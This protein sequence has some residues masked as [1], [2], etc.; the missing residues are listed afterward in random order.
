[1]PSS[2]FINSTSQ[3]FQTSA[4]IAQKLLKPT[5][6]SCN[7]TTKPPGNLSVFASA[8]KQFSYLL[9]FKPPHASQQ[10]NNTITLKFTYTNLTLKL[11][12]V[13]P[14]SNW[15]VPSSNSTHDS[16]SQKASKHQ[17]ST[18][19]APKLLNLAPPLAQSTWNR[20]PHTGSDRRAPTQL[21]HKRS[22][23]QS[24]HHHPQPSESGCLKTVPESR[25][26]NT[27]ANNSFQVQTT[28]SSYAPPSPHIASNPRC[29]DFFQSEP[30]PQWWPHIRMLEIYPPHAQEWVS[31]W[32]SGVSVVVV[33]ASRRFKTRV[34]RCLL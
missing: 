14:S 9:P 31:K 33:V 15:E 27:C 29:G 22:P 23:R 5:L 19:L 16:P 30:S 34:T 20:R 25:S 4:H 7:K 28:S 26:F 13:T 24:A 32:V 3:S 1:M 2:N 12:K 6:S 11:N 18:A 8:E 21:A 10:S 17:L